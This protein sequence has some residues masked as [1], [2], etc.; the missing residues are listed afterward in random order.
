MTFRG[1]IKRLIKLFLFWVSPKKQKWF[2]DF[3]FDIMQPLPEDA[4][5]KLKIVLEHFQ[6]EISNFR[7]SDGT[8]LGIYRDGKLIRHDNDFDFDVEFSVQN[9]R[10]VQSFARKQSWTLGRHVK[11]H[12][13]TQ[14]LSY[15]DS[16]KVIHDFIFWRCDGRFSI[17]F[18]EPSKYR[19]MPEYFLTN[20]KEEFVG[21]VGVNV[22][23]PLDVIDWA[24]FR[25]GEAWKVPEIQKGDWTETCGDLGHAWWLG[26]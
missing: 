22:N 2:H 11:F 10:R 16:D 15:F 13:E 24:V 9:V 8:L 5:E 26:E 18:S 19:V 7:V 21:T 3:D 23:L 17:N 14:Q 4:T 20:L 6:K 12:G 25:Y 1:D